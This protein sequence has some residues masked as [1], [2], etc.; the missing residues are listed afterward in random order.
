MTAWKLYFLHLS[1]EGLPMKKLKYESFIYILEYL[2]I[3]SMEEAPQYQEKEL[4]LT[5]EEY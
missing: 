2:L 1:V 3:L 4:K 5:Y